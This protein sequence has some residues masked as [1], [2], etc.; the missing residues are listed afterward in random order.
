M[1][2]RCW[3]GELV[4][5]GPCLRCGFAEVD[6]VCSMY[7]SGKDGIEACD[8]CGVPNRPPRDAAGQPVRVPTDRLGTYSYAIDAEIK[9]SHQYADHLKK[10]NL[11]L[12]NG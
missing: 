1:K 8:K 4:D 7:R 5:I 6:Y 9:T 3:N 10:N 12:Q 2:S 11:G